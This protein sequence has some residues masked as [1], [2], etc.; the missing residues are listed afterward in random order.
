M[1][2][3]AKE[4]MENFDGKISECSIMYFPQVNYILEFTVLA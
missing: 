1:A 2:K 3:V 4:E